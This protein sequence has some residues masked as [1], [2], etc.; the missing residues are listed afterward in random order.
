VRFSPAGEGD[1]VGGDFYDIFAV[2]APKQWA[3]IIGDVCGKGA[4]AAAMTAMARWTLRALPDL[5]PTDALRHLNETMLRQDLGSTFITVAAM[6]IRVE[7]DHALIEV[8]CGGHPAP[9]HVRRDG[10]ASAIDAGGDLI[11]IWPT[12]RLRP[13]EVR[14]EPG[15]LLV[16]FTDGATDFTTEPLQRLE[17]LLSHIAPGDA[18]GAASAVE[19]H[20]LE[21]AAATRDDIAVVAIAFAGRSG[22]TLAP[23]RSLLA[24]TR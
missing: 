19:H 12:L 4:Q 13:A 21:G 23:S 18:A 7:S 9:I 15:E 22:A 8:A 2:A 3:V 11:G 1:L 14:L 16:A 20:A 5:P 24:A 17:D 6:R 10:T